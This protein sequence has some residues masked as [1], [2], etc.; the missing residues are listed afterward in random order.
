[1]VPGGSF[2]RSNNAAYPAT[3][4]GFLLDRFEVTVGRFRKFVEAYPASKPTAGAGAHP[5]IAGSGWDRA[6]DQANLPADLAS[7]K[8]E[9]A[10]GGY[11]TWTDDPGD[12]AHLPI[13]CITWYVAFAFC[14]WDGGRLPTEAEWNFAAAGGDEQREYP[15]GSGVDMDH[16]AYGCLGDG[17]MDC[18]LSDIFPVG[19]KPSGVGRWGHMDLAGGLSEWA[20]D[21]EGAYPDVCNDCA[22]IADDEGRTNR[23]LC[24][25]N[26][27]NSARDMQ[28]ALRHGSLP[29]SR[30]NHVGIRCARDM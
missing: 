9:V 18:A 22:D 28:T 25:G 11:Q 12:H 10:C 8:A 5:Q 29:S 26:F 15:W 23:A 6:W 17:V 20:L 3:V 13:N 4:S 30:S 21:W 2:N 27:G 24:G 14:A 16:V 7:L 19:S 1:M